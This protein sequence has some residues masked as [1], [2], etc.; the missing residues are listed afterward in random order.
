MIWVV[1]LSAMDLSTHGLT[2]GYYVL[3]FGV[4]QDLAGGETPSS[5]Q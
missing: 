3:A 4:Y 1:S 2:P 5:N